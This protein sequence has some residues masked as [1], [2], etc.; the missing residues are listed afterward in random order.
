MRRIKL[1]MLKEGLR[2]ISLKNDII[3]VES[4]NKVLIGLKRISE[5]CINFY[6]DINAGYMFYFILYFFN[7]LFSL[8]KK[9]KSSPEQN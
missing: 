3:K 1:A 7:D 5:A 2:W 6:K 9:L 4:Q 8:D